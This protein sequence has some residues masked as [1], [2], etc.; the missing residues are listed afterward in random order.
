M[1]AEIGIEG[2]RP[3]IPERPDAIEDRPRWLTT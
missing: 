1:F 2:L 3:W